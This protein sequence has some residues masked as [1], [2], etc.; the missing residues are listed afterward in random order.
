MKFDSMLKQYIL[1]RYGTLKDFAAA[2][3]ISYSTMDAI[4]R[5]GSEK[6]SVDNIIKICSVL[7]IK[8]DELIEGRIV[9]VDP[10]EFPTEVYSLLL[11]SDRFTLDGVQ[12][13]YE[14]TQILSDCIENAC[15]IIRRVRRMR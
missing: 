11:M 4:F 7:G 3:D 14:E 15:H 9:P 5:R 13:S 6:T 2:C 10:E 1:S 8:T 12:L